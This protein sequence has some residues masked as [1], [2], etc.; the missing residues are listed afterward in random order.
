MTRRE[1]GF[2]LIELLVVVAIIG[3]IAAIA[4]PNLLTAI[5]RAKQRR[6]MVDM[7]NMASAWESRNT[8]AGR[9]NA[10]GQASGVEG[11][12]KLVTFDDFKLMLSPTY[13]RVLPHFD[14]WGTPYQAYTNQSFGGGTRADV[15]AIISG[16]KDGV[17]NTDAT[18][19]PFTNFDC[20][21]VYS[22]GVF[23]S[24]PDGL[25]FNK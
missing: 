18:T 7:R 20:D 6:T 3:I 19:G 21:I 4:I 2:T 16:G 8:E 15:Y 17:I 25:T 5:Q 11:A 10:A 23:L 13:I 12:D 22:N 14:G 9:Y 1:K 24:Y